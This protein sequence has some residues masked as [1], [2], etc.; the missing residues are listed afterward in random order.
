MSD[1]VDLTRLITE[2]RKLATENAQF[3]EIHS[4]Q[5]LEIKKL[6]DEIESLR[7]KN[8]SI[9]KANNQLKAD[10]AL[11]VK[12]EE[13]AK[14][15][16]R[17]AKRQMREIREDAKIQREQSGAIKAK[18]DELA[19][20]K[21][22]FET[23]LKLARSEI[24]TLRSQNT[25]LEGEK[26]AIEARLVAL[27]QTQARQKNHTKELGLLCQKYYSRVYQS[28]WNRIFALMKY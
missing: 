15:L 27:E 16:E 24:Q 5:N 21:S 1:G 10:L 11:R 13:G 22:E 19:R 20:N 26:G 2:T 17:E 23:R 8:D 18:M 28:C 4:R 25:E 7:G 14:Q 6:K 3:C 9:V 12:A